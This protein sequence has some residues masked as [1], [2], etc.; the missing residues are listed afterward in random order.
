MQFRVAEAL[1]A[2]ADWE[3]IID[4]DGPGEAADLV[5]LRRDGENHLNLTLVHCKYSSEDQPG[6]RIGD[7]YEVCGQAAKCHKARSEV[8]V[9]LRK[10]LRREERRQARGETGF[11]VGGELDLIRSWTLHG[12]LI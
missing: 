5:C 3:V 12:C 1:A 6:S 9:I 10:L 8:E 2:E 11:V 4:D 7:L